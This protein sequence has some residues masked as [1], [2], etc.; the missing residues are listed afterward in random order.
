MKNLFT[1]LPVV[2]LVVLSL[3]TVQTRDWEDPTITQIN[4]LEP[5]GYKNI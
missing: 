3:S 5:V 2:V 1:I 4:K